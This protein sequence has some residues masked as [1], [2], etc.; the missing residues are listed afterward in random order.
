MRHF[1][2]FLAFLGNSIALANAPRVVTTT[3]DLAWVAG[4]LLGDT[5]TPVRSFLSGTENP[6]YADASPNFIRWAADADIVCLVGL[7]LEVGWLPKVLSR[8]GNS[9]VQPGGSGYCDVGKA[10]KALEIP[11]GPV[12]RSM[13][14]V[15]PLGNPHFWL[16]P[17]ALGQGA[18]AVAD[19][20]A[21]A[22]PSSAAL[23]QS[24]LK[25]L[26]NRLSKLHATNKK[27][28][29]TLKKKPLV[30]EYHKEFTYFLSAY[31]IQ[32]F[33]SIEEKP[34]VP[35]SA[36]RIAEIAQRAKRAG[37]TLVLA[38]EYSPKKT[39]ERFKELSGIPIVTVPTSLSKGQMD[40]Q[41][42]Q[43]SLI[44]RIVTVA[45]EH[46]ASSKN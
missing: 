16:S 14:D 31:G 1:F 41:A 35:P 23:Y 13:G 33:G 45:G 28:L 17:P 2:L 21:A 37:V 26:Q 6:H 25:Q 42:Y 11:E 4:E 29:D 3:T 22:N 10:I 12:D 43:D 40:Y 39:L 19:V 20:L 30:I 36:G 27:R 46:L 7:D 9:K 8:S 24:R 32:S 5:K 15:H 18:Q 34:G 44:E 38:A